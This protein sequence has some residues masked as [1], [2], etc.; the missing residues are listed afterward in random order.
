MDGMCQGT[1]NGYSRVANGVNDMTYPVVW[2]E[3][4]DQFQC[5]NPDCPSGSHAIYVNPRCHPDAGIEAFYFDGWMHMH[6]AYCNKPIMRMLVPSETLNAME[7]DVPSM[8]KRFMEDPVDPSTI[9]PDQRPEG[10]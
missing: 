1:Q 9:M 10:E 6:C 8:A 3:Q 5:E 7:Q 4:A 2:R